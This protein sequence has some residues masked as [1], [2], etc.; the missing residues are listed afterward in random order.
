MTTV[1]RQNAP[2]LDRPPREEVPATA[3]PDPAGVQTPD[4]QS[5]DDVF[6]P[7]PGA[8]RHPV[9]LSFKDKV[10]AFIARLSTRN[11]FWHRVCSMIWLPYAFRSG[12]RM[13][14]VNERTFSAELPFR[15]FN[16]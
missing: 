6:Q 13:K 5:E 14:R 3:A 2:G 4:A 7:G 1:P 15:R 11:Q 10:E 16:R 12:I 9:A 8:A